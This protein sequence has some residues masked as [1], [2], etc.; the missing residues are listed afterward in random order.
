MKYVARKILCPGLIVL[1]LSLIFVFMASAE[2]ADT[3]LDEDLTPVANESITSESAIVIDFTTGL[4][5]YELNAD[6]QR[7]PASMIKAV[8]VYVIF[9]AIR[10]G[11]VNLDSSI[12]I[13]NA[14][15]AF[16][17]VSAF[18]NVPMPPGSVYT[19]KELL[20]IILVRS[21]SAAIISAGEGIFGSED[22]LVLKMNEKLQQLGITGKVYDSWG[23][24]PNNRI[25]AK[26][27]AELTR[28]FI[29]DY[30]EILE[31]TSQTSVIFDEE[32]YRTT[33]SL[34]RSYYGADGF[35]TG[36]TRPAGW[37]FTGTAQRDGRRIITVTMGSERGFRFPDTVYLLDHGFEHY[38]FTIANHIRNSVLLSVKEQNIQKTPLIPLMMYN[39][40]EAE[41][42]NIRDLAVILNETEKI[43]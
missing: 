35:K 21:A 41:Y 40:Y 10:D 27:I 29:N 38:N 23:G 28:A 1:L 7:V 43:D 6:E 32:E 42:I 39:I 14:T 33:N 16:S 31:L 19:L 12:E 30:P 5:I 13:S 37:C 3:D 4:V 17:Y 22:T 2:P 25:S 20:D 34:I 8:A 15:S 18:S 9:D 26:G 24:S 11:M 36:F